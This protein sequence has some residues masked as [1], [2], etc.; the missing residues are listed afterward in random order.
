VY[1]YLGAAELAIYSFAM[2]P[3]AHAKQFISPIATLGVPKLATRPSQQIDT[4][5]RRRTMTAT[6]FGIGIVI[7]YCVL[8]YPFFY[9]FFPKYIDAIPYSQAYSLVLL[10][11]SSILLVSAAIDSRITLVPK[12]LLYLWNL[13]SIVLA[14]CAILLIQ[15]LGLW[16][17]II[18]QLLA[19]S[20]TAI[21]SWFVWYSIRTKEHEV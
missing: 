11:Q 3:V 20:T 2:A 1:H 19:L 17:A 18:G 9:I 21:L 6:L 12:P 4:M 5:L 7:T 14:I 16:G 15:R 8:A 13:P 10:I